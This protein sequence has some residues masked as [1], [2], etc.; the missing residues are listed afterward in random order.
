MASN[1]RW[2]PRRVERVL[3]RN[4]VR[5]GRFSKREFESRSGEKI[6]FFLFG[7]ETIF[8]C[9]GK[10]IWSFSGESVFIFH[11]VVTS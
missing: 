9:Q 2:R 5:F 8:F 7:G 1:S 11:I 3:G 6:S 4:G 10:G